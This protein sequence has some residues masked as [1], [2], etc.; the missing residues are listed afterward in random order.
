LDCQFKNV[1]HQEFKLIGGPCEGCEAIFEYGDKQLYNIDTLPDFEQQGPKLKISGTVYKHGSRIPARDVILYI[2]H[3]SQEG[4]YP[5][6]GNEKGWKKRHGYLRGWIKTDTNGK[7]TF[8]TLVPGAYPNRNNP[9]HIHIIVLEPDGK[10]YYI[11]EFLFAGDPL[12]TD[13]RINRTDPR[14][15][16]GYILH[17]IK[18]NDMLVATRNIEL[19]KNVPGYE[20]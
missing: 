12:L 3:T 8:Y 10:Y 6:R 20:D 17:P 2:Y 5:T 7:Y 13:D 18:Q 1:S 16:Y 9:K 19:G 11:E 15:G 4:I 14:G